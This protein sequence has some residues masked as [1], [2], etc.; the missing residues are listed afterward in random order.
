MPTVMVGKWSKLRAEK[1]PTLIFAGLGVADTLFFEGWKL[2]DT[3]FRD[4]KPLSIKFKT[5]RELSAEI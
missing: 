5:L 2:A 4:E 1:L 3:K